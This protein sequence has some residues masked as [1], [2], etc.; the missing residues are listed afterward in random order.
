MATLASGGHLVPACTPTRCP[1]S[2]RGHRHRYADLL[3]CQH[4]HPALTDESPASRGYEGA[5]VTP[6]AERRRRTRVWRQA[7]RLRSRLRPLGASRAVRDLRPERL[8]PSDI[9]LA[10]ISATI[11]ALVVSARGG[12]SSSSTSSTRPRLPLMPQSGAARE[13]A[14]GRH[15]PGDPSQRG[16]GD[17]WPGT[18][19]LPRRCGSR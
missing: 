19:N 3:P 1:S 18:P 6:R 8:T 14:P 17:H 10:S 4:D 5:C 2:T 7:G 16:D 15:W 9:R 11:V 12:S 13:L